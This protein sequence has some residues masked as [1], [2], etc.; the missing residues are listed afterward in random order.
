[1]SGPISVSHYVTATE[2]F[3]GVGEVTFADVAELEVLGLD[4]LAVIAFRFGAV[5]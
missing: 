3:V 5:V 4:A 1:M 2:E